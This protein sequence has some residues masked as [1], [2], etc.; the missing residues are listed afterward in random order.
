MAS[1]SCFH[2]AVAFVLCR[3]VWVWVCLGG[4][5]R[6]LSVQ[7]PHDDNEKWCVRC[8]ARVEGLLNVAFG[9]SLL[10]MPPPPPPP[11]LPGSG[12]SSVRLSLLVHR[13]I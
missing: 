9:V 5:F 2:I 13:R 7:T 3:C 11:L 8:V 6:S 12:R 4:D 1:S 10:L